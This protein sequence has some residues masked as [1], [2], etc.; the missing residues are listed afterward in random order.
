MAIFEHVADTA[1]SIITD[2]PPF[3]LHIT[4]ALANVNQQIRR[5]CLHLFA[6]RAPYIEVTVTDFDFS[7]AIHCL[8]KLISAPPKRRSGFS[9]PEHRI[10]H[11]KL[12]FS[13]KE[14]SYPCDSLNRWL[15]LI[16]RKDNV[17][18]EASTKRWF[19]KAHLDREVAGVG[20]IRTT[21]S[22]V[23]EKHDHNLRDNT[24]SRGLW[25]VVLCQEREYAWNK[26]M[27]HEIDGMAAT[28]V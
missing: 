25:F 26:K 22:S 15:S 18:R 21:Y 12:R 19:P 13:D 9:P 14:P 6:E 2:V 4:G 20:S 23:V 7:N 17:G 28:F 1:N 10:L 24:L 5:E 16:E 27:R 11:I 8:E 3:G